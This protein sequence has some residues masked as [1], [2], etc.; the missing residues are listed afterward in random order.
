MEKEMR[1]KAPHPVAAMLLRRGFDVLVSN[2]TEYL[3]FPPDLEKPFEDELYGMLKKYSFR[4][5][6]RDVIKNRR[7]FRAGDLLKYS[8]LEWV[9]RYLKFLLDRRVI[10]ETGGGAY[11]LKAE[12]VFSFGDTL[13][14]FVANAFEREFSSP[15]LW[16][17]RL[18]GGAAGGD[19]DVV[20]SVEGRLVYVEVK[21]SPPKNIEEPEVAAFIRRVLELRPSLA[22][23]LEDTR[24]RMK[25]KI[26]PFFEDLLKGRAIERVEGETFT[27]EG[28][29]FVTNSHPGLVNNL[30]LCIREHLR[31]RAFWT[32]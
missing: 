12:A 32:D 19:Y 5:F 6:V 7:S 2:P 11:R 30:A 26:M 1:D 22:V 10:E 3:F 27:I 4:L 18:K 23:F 8:S 24:L 29:I 17:V 25:D 28:R 16:G 9:E 14:W 15:A 21:S 31:P 13:E 20:A